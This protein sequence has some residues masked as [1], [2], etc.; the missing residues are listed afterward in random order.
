MTLHHFRKKRKDHW[1]PSEIW[2]RA[3]PESKAWELWDYT[4]EATIALCKPCHRR[5]EAYQGKTRSR[6]L[7]FA[8]VFENG[9]NRRVGPCGCPDCSEQ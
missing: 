9:H 7:P 1:Y 2:R 3:R 4:L 5:L 6:P 8:V